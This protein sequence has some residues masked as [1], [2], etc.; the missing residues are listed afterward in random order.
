VGGSIIG[1]PLRVWFNGRTNASQALSTGSIPVTRS[2]E[3][4]PKWV[5]FSWSG[6]VLASTSLL[7]PAANATFLPLRVRTFG[8]EIDLVA[9]P[10]LVNGPVRVGNVVTCSCWLSGRRQRLG[11]LRRNGRRDGN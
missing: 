2:L 6:P 8:G 10:A 11:E 7:I 9:E 1:S 4:G 3:K 5:L